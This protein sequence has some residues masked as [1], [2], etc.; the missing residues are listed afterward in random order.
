[1]YITFL[2]S[3]STESME[4]SW[5]SPFMATCKLRFIIIIIIICC[6]FCCYCFGG[7]G[8]FDEFIL[9]KV[10]IIW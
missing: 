2:C 4:D 3:N 8:D 1:M 5:N 9:P 10:R 7:G 6:C